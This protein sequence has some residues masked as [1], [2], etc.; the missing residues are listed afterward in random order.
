MILVLIQ[1]LNNLKVKGM[2]SAHLLF[3]T[4]LEIITEIPDI[5]NVLDKI[6][7]LTGV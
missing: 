6:K 7:N 4:R 5:F 1:S 2:N 3:R